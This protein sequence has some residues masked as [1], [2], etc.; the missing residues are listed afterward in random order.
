EG[1]IR[2]WS[3]TGVQTCALPISPARVPRRRARAGRVHQ[4]ERVPAR[5]GRRTLLLRVPRGPPAAQGVGG[6]YRRGQI[7]GSGTVAGGECRSEERRVGQRER[8]QGAPAPA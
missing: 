2:Y 3:V 4:L 6:L 5:T 7:F 8:S 1:G